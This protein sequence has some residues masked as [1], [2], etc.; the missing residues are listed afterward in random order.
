MHLFILGS[1]FLAPGLLA[2]S[3][4]SKYHHSSSQRAP[5]DYGYGSLHH[6]HTNNTFYGADGEEMLALQASART[7]LEADLDKYATLG[8]SN[9][10][11]KENMTIRKEW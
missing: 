4:P 2:R 11:T 7:N 9:G 3:L 5:P 8:A 10:C 6:A 1:L